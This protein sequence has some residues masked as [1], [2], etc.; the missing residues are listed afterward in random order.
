MVRGSG[1][2]AKAANSPIEVKW[3]ETG[4]FIGDKGKE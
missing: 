3:L 2:T 1:S 4:R